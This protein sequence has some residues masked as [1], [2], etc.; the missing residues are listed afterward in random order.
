MRKIL[1]TIMMMAMGY[2]LLVYFQTTEPTNDVPPIVVNPVTDGDITDTPVTM[3]VVNSTYRVV[4][5]SYTG[6]IGVTNTGTA[7]IFYQDDSYTFLLTNAHVVKIQA[8]YSQ[9]KLSI[10]DYYGQIYDATVYQGTYQ[11]SYDL[12]ILIVEKLD[13]KP[14]TIYDGQATN[15]NDEVVAIGY[16]PTANV[17]YGHITSLDRIDYL[18]HM[19]V[20]GHTASIQPGASG[21]PLFNKN[22]ELIGINYSSVSS[23]GQFIRAYSIPSVKIIEYLNDYFYIGDSNG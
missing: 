22:L 17:T 13:S 2:T 18:V 20:I 16:Y 14:V 21:G 23:S 10:T 4:N 19:N 11:E 12:A 3:D 7:V 1:F 15:I 8:G 5:R 9:N 6:D